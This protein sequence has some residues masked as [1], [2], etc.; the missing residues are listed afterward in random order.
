MSC[1]RAVSAAQVAVAPETTEYEIVPMTGAHTAFEQLYRETADR[2]YGLC[3]R[4]TGDRKRAAELAQEVFVRVWRDRGW[5]QPEPRLALGGMRDSVWRLAVRVALGATRTATH[6]LPPRAH[7]A[8]VLH[9]VEGCADPVVAELLGVPPAEARA[10]LGEARGH[11]LSDAAARTRSGPTAMPSSV[12]RHLDDHELGD[13]VD[14]LLDAGA[15]E[16]AREHLARCAH[17]RTRH[18]AL[19]SLISRARAARSAVTVPPELWTV[20]AAAT[21]YAPMVRRYLTRS[22]RLAFVVGGVMLAL[23]GAGAMALLLLR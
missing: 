15:S 14:G 12:M 19:R 22:P 2:V 13:L 1:A 18:D 20:V 7:A 6:D 5:S 21:V 11:L 8:F 16:A 10:L 9:D 3:L 17:C 4:M 23:A